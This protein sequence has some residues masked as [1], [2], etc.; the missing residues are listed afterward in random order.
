MAVFRYDGPASLTVIGKVTGRK[1]WF[2]QAGAE[3]AVDMRD[4]S[5]VSQ[6]PKLALVR[7]A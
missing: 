2:A 5:S 7:L 3:L 1:Y 6:V 4:R